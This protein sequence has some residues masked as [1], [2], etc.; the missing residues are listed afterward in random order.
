MY[1]H[2]FMYQRDIQGRCIK[3]FNKFNI[4]PKVLYNDEKQNRNTEQKYCK[5]ILQHVYY[6]NF[7]A[8]SQFNSA[9]AIV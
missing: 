6:I 8:E 9:K 5:H 3:T 7:F 4:S 1:I 2:T